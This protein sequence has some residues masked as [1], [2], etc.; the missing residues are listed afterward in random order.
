[1][2]DPLSLSFFRWP[3]SRSCAQLPLRQNALR[4]MTRSTIG[5]HQPLR[6]ARRS[7]TRCAAVPAISLAAIVLASCGASQSS[8]SELQLS[9]C[10]GSA[11]SAT[12][13]KAAV[14][15]G[16][17]SSVH[18][19]AITNRSANECWLIGWPRLKAEA[20]GR[21][22]K[23]TYTRESNVWGPIKFKRVFLRPG[24]SA[25]SYVQLGQ[26]TDLGKCEPT[27]W[28]IAVGT[29]RSESPV[30][31]SP[32]LADDAGAAPALCANT[33]Y[34]RISPMFPAS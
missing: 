13:P 27:T 10:H 31:S 5:N 11:L 12:W 1:M 14:F 25:A 16:M 9:Q 3:G 30:K 8:A 26:P 33:G 29:G 20:S 19:L 18:T 21:P 23:I 24:R 4:W 15:G 7:G 28:L 17:G 2:S 6:P 22:F 32:G 34:V